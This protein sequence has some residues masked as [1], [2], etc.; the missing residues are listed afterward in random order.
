VAQ[1]CRVCIFRAWCGFSSRLSAVLFGR[2]QLSIFEPHF[3]TLL[4]FLGT[5]FL[6]Y[7]CL[8]NSRIS[9]VTVPLLRNQPFLFYREY[10]LRPSFFLYYFT[11]Q[12]VVTCTDFFAIPVCLHFLSYL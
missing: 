2:L 9:F 10:F 5:I 8:P 12:S 3:G 4:K 1:L 7:I 6:Y 11:S